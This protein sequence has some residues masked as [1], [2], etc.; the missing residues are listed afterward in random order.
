MHQPRTGPSHSWASPADFFDLFDALPA[1]ALEL[2]RAVGGR[3]VLD[4]DPLKASSQSVYEQAGDNGALLGRLTR[5]SE[6]MRASLTGPGITAT[7]ADAGQPAERFISFTGLTEWNWNVTANR[8]EP[9]EL[10]LTLSARL[11]AL[12]GDPYEPITPDF[13]RHKTLSVR[14]PQPSES[15]EPA[16]P[17]PGGTPP[18]GVSPPSSQPSSPSDSTFP[19]WGGIALGVLVLLLLALV[20]WQRKRFAHWGA[21][22]PIRMRSRKPLATA[23]ILHDIQEREAAAKLCDT[24][25]TQRFRFLTAP[26]GFPQNDPRWQELFRANLAQADVVLMLLTAGAFAKPGFQAQVREA[27]EIQKTRRFRVFPVAW[28]AAVRQGAA[29]LQEL[30]QLSWESID[31]EFGRSHLR[32]ALESA[33]LVN[34]EAI[35]CFL[36]YSRQDLDFAIRLQQRLENSGIACWRDESDIHLGSS[37][38]EEIA[39]AIE[40]ATHMLVVVTKAA[41]AS[42]NVEQEIIYAQERNKIVIPLLLDSPRLPFGLNATQGIDLT[43]D[44]QGGLDRLLLSLTRGG[45]QAGQSAAG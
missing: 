11:P 16:V 45:K 38:R 33:P 25:G 7:P 32:K 39:Q 36:S 2:G 15:G 5:R 42:K 43:K 37:W 44:P 9:Q 21:L 3:L 27:L 4:P 20:I 40:A 13:P 34:A 1:R 35:S 22:L 23:V 14:Q 10:T 24:I 29:I 26:E 12:P 6:M 41:T 8:P 30:S 28:D 18:P 17:T 19:P 31:T